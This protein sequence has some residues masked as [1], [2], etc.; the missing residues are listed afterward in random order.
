[1]INLMINNLIQKINQTSKVAVISHINPDGDSL[2]S[3]IGLGIALNKICDDITIYNTDIVPLK[4]KFLP[5]IDLLT[6]YDNYPECKYDFCFVLDCGDEDRLGECK[7]I[8]NQSKT[9]INIDH[10]ISNTMFGDVNIV[11]HDASATCEIIYHIL[12]DNFIIDKNIATCLYTGILTDTGNFTYS[13]T[14]YKTHEIVS[15]LVKTGIDIEN[16]SF[17]LYQNNSLQSVKLTGSILSNLEVT[18]GG[19]VSFVTITCE[20]VKSYGVTIDEVDSVVNFA[21]DIKGIEVAILIK[22]Q[23]NSTK[24]SLRSKSNF[25]VSEIARHFNG[26]GHKKAAGI[27]TTCTPIEIK[28]KIKDILSIYLGR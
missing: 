28:N 19:K 5:N 4:F 20:Q 3:T 25:D 9:V 8:L 15:K 16:I 13:N 7:R 27:T 23:F 17:N 14:T 18:M 22:E 21:R 2:G 10:H 26:G 11:D 6:K 12:E 1:M 24:V